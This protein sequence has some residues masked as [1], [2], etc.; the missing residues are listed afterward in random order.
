MYNFPFPFRIL[1][2]CLL[3]LVQ[4]FSISYKKLRFKIFMKN[5]NQCIHSVKTSNEKSSIKLPS[6]IELK[7]SNCKIE[8]FLL[9][10]IATRDKSISYLT[11][12]TLG[13]AVLAKNL[14]Q[15]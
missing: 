15:Q 7:R 1:C 5:K 2:L 6:K 14:N 4:N 8:L 12:K 3:Q 10:Y 9:L 11:Q 13:K